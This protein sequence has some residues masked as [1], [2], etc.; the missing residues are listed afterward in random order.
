MAA[1]WA[2]I[3]CCKKAI[4]KS[5]QGVI[6]PKKNNIRNRDTAALMDGLE[7]II[8]RYLLY[9]GSLS[10]ELMFQLSCCAKAPNI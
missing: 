4:A 7:I 3:P 2:V 9:L 1:V 8:T 6:D 5:P 10:H